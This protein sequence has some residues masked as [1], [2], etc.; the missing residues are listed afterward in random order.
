MATKRESATHETQ[1]GRSRDAGHAPVERA[2]EDERQPL[3]LPDTVR[4]LLEESRMVLPGI[5]ALFGFQLIAVFNQRFQELAALERYV[6]LSAI[7]L[8]AIAVALVM[9]PAAYQRQ[10]EPNEVSRGFVVLASR[11]L[12]SSM[13][14]L[15]AGISLDLYLIA[16][17]ISG[18]PWIAALLGAAIFGVFFVL[19]FVVPRTPAL[20]RRLRM[21]SR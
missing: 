14:P 17:L 4:I 1:D 7:V 8:V 19:W 12:L 16:V 20:Q 15:M 21:R 18:T 10:A 9:A 2:S 13:L 3:P 5:Q 6:H 11:L